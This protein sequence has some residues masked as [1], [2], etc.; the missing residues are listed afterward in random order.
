MPTRTGSSPLLR[1]PDRLPGSCI[2]E[3]HQPLSSS[4]FGMFLQVI[5]RP[6][7]WGVAQ[8]RPCPCGIRA[9]WQGAP[10]QSEL[11]PPLGS[12]LL[13]EPLSGL[14]PGLGFLGDRRC[15]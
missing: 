13:V 7:S 10:W 11:G 5:S 14:S 6:A 4:C 9:S 8:L 2:W 12:D 15:P 3:F 1:E